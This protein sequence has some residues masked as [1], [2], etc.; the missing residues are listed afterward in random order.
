MRRKFL[1]TRKKKGLPVRAGAIALMLA[2]V[3]ALGVAAAAA[4]ASARPQ[5]AQ[6][7]AA[8]GTPRI[9]KQFFG[10]A[11]DPSTGKST[12]TYRYTLTNGAGM[13]VQLLSY[14]AITQAI[15]VPG[16]QRQGRRR[17]ARLQDPQ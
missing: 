15:D 13:T 14:G 9:T 17:G 5:A 6:Q 16:T 2:V 10:N 8:H 3:A 11:T 1:I 7:A 12:P 4:P